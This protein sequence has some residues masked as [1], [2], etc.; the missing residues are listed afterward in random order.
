MSARKI[1]H[2]VPVS[3]AAAML[4]CSVRTLQRHRSAGKLEFIRRGRCK[5]CIREEVELLV[6]SDRTEWL[7]AQL[8]APASDHLTANE[9]FALWADLQDRLARITGVPLDCVP[10]LREVAPRFGHRRMGTVKAR[11]LAE[12]I[13]ALDPSLRAKFI[14]LLALAGLPP[15][16]GVLD[17]RRQIVAAYTGRP[18]RAAGVSGIDRVA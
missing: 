18:G 9:W 4:G 3:E 1:P 7:A 6:A 8:L 17:A 2:L 16:L 12:A 15:D 13:D 11:D 5:F 10:L 14:G